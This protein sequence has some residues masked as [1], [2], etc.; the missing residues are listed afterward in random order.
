VLFADIRGYTSTTELLDLPHLA[1]LLGSFYENC[2]AAI[3]ERE[4]IVNKLIGDAILALFNFPLAHDDH[5]ARAVAAG[6]ELQR[7][8]ANLKA[9][10]GREAR[11]SADDRRVLRTGPCGAPGRRAAHVRAQGN[12]EARGGVRRFLGGGTMK[13]P[14]V[15]AYIAKAAPFARPI[16]E[17]IRRLFHQAC[18]Q[19]EERLKWGCPSF[20]HKGMVGGMAAFKAH[21]AFGLWRQDV[22]PAPRGMFRSKSPMGSDRYTDV[23]QL[24]PDAA[25]L[26]Y[27]R[28]AVKLN[29]DGPP[30]RAKSRP[31]PPVKAPAYF[32]AALRKSGKALATF[33]AFPPSKRRDYVEWIVEAK[34]ESTREKRLA[35]AVA[36]M[37]QGKSRNWKYE[38]C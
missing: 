34:Q 5:V 4:G 36:W 35:T 7:R 30:S 10:G 32:M 21:A 38:K 24:P 13:N 2:A 12:R 29:E 1:R 6:I 33:E 14:E 3:W 17:K 27:I 37:A 25:L 8:C 9:P 20:E 18:P 19:I 16:L 31:K 22:L 28:A 15:D 23:S 26:K 11:R